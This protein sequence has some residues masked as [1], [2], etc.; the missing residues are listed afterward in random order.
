M[1]NHVHTAFTR[2]LLSLALALGLSACGVTDRM[3]K[4]VD[5]TW[6]GDVLFSGAEKLVLTCDGGNH[7]NPDEAGKPLSV[8]LRV[9]QLTSLER[10]ATVDADSLWLEPQKA[11]G[12]TLVDSR[13]LTLLPGIGQ[14]ETTVLPTN[15]GYVGV[16]A[17]FRSEK[18]SRWK[19]AFDAN[20]LR[21][22][23]VWSS[24]KELRLLVDNNYILATRGNDV[25]ATPISKQALA[26]GDQM[27]V[28]PTGQKDHQAVEDQ[29]TRS[30]R[31]AGQKT[32]DVKVDSRME[33]SQ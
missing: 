2:H 33:S 8:V 25:L 21:K 16:A 32:F 19:V 11:L 30:A 10:F 22:D 14:V 15:I 5:D 3:G 4:Q 18:D 6:A 1:M 28:S 31:N 13:E 26:R 17:F 29:A 7:L 20:S 24:E 9:Y 12:S 27:P 23:G